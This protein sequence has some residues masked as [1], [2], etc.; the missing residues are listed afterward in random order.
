MEIF[1]AALILGLYALILAMLG[2][3]FGLIDPISLVL[4]GLVLSTLPFV[5]E[6]KLDPKLVLA[7]FLPPVLYQAA[8][9]LSWREMKAN[10]RAILFL[11]VALVLATAVGVAGV[12]WLVVPGMTIGAAF[13]LGAIVS[14]PD[15]VAATAVLSKVRVPRRIVTILEGESLINDATALVFY[16]FA[17]KAV[18]TGHFSPTAALGDFL[19]VAI[20]GLAVGLVIG[21]ISIRLHRMIDDPLMEAMISLVVPFSAFLVAEHVH[22]SGVLAVVAAGLLRAAYS[23][24][25]IGAASRL[26]I[27]SMWNI[28]VFVL[29]ALGFLLIGTQ[30]PNVIGNLRGD[31]S[32]IALVAFALAIGV[33]VVG[34]RFLWIYPTAWLS[35]RLSSYVRRHDPMPSAGTLFIMSWSGMRGIVSL[36]AALA[37]PSVLDD[38]LTPFPHRDMILFLTYCTILMTL[39]GQGSTLGW[40]IRRLNVEAAACSP[41][42]NRQVRAELR[43]AGLAA[44]RLAAVGK[45]ETAIDRLGKHYEEM[46]TRLK[47]PQS[48]DLLEELIEKDA[49]DYRELASIA[50]KAERARLAEMRRHDRIEDDLANELQQELDLHEILIGTER[51]IG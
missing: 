23:G 15:A 31:Y 50:L 22:A 25:V 39:V 12:A 42:T 18:V 5:P 41:G 32:P 24:K 33:A 27:Y 36:V 49:A 1:T 3:R 43:E 44:L 45:S 51:G 30:L 19:W 20:A 17:V 14:P 29:N 38:G 9:H 6:L 34:V 26:Q 13:V 46:L 16:S 37:L 21:K 11:A 10:M 2:R 8:L 4:G 35:R 48:D 28:I 7:L 40:F 47:A